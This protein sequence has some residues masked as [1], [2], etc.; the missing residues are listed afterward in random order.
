MHDTAQAQ[1]HKPWA[2]TKTTTV[3]DAAHVAAY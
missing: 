2:A 1:H 3:K